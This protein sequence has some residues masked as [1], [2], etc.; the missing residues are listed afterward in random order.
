MYEVVITGKENLERFSEIV[1]W[2]RDNSI[3]VKYNPVDMHE[4]FSVMITFLNDNDYTLFR[5]KYG[6]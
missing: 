1:D 6:I 4:K 5:L 2:L 3:A